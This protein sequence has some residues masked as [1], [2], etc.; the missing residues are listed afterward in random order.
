MSS[1]P[2]LIVESERMGNSQEPSRVDA[3]YFDPQ[4]FQELQRALSHDDPKEDARSDITDSTIDVDHNFDFGKKLQRIV[5]KADEANIKM[6]QLG[7]MF[8]DLRVVGVAPAAS[9]IPTVGGVFNPLAILENIQNLRHPRLKTILSGFEGVVRP[10]EMLLVLG[11]PEAGS[12]TFL[13]MLAN[14]RSEY[15]AVEGDVYYDSISPSDIHNHYRGDVQYSP[16]DDIHFPTLTVDQTLKFASTTRTPREHLTKTRRQFSRKETDMLTTVFGLRHAK[17]TPVGNAAIRGVSG[18]EKKRV[19]IAESLATRALISCWDNSTRGLDS[20]TALE[21]VR[22]LR[23]AT[24]TMH[25]TTVAAIYQASESIYKHFDKVCVLYEGQ[26]AYFGSANKARQYFIDMGYEP[27]NRQT[28]SDFLVAVTDPNG[29]ITRKGATNVPR[30]A[31]EF[32]EYFR[33]SSFAAMNRSDMASYEA[34]YVGNEK[35]ALEYKESARA[36]LAK[37][38]SKGS[39]YLLTIPQQVRAVMLR[40]A[41]I[42]RGEMFVTCL[43][44]FIFTFQALIMGSLFYKVQDATS[45]YFS[46]G[47]VLFFS[48]FFS[49]LTAMAEIP[50]LYAQR[51]IVLR[52]QQAAMYHP[53]VETL[54]LTLVDIPITIVTL[55]IFSIV[56]YFLVGFQLSAGQFFI[57]FLFVV[58]TNLTMKA[59]FRGIA[60]AFTSEPVADSVGG[61]S[62]LAVAIYTG[63][64]I[65]KPSMIGALRWISY[66]NPMRYS[67]EAIITNEFRTLQGTCSSLVPR[68]LGY[69]NVSMANQVCTTL[70]SI[71]GQPY[72]EGSSF[73]LLSYGFKFSHTWMNL[74]IVLG[75]FIG[76]LLCLLAFTELN[77]STSHEHSMA[78]FKRNSKPKQ[79]LSPATP[80]VENLKEKEDMSA[81]KSESRLSGKAGTAVQPP[82]TDIFSWHD[83]SYTVHADSESK[84]LLDDISGY[85]AP[86]KLTALMG[87]SG[88]GKTTL[89]NVLAQRVSTGVVRGDFLVNGQTLPIDFQAQT[90]YCQQMDTHVPTATVREALLFSAQLRQPASVPLE[91]KEAY[92]ELC[93][94]MCGLEEYADASVGSLGV[95]HRKRTTIAVELAAKPKLL[96]FL[97]EPTSGLD[98]QSA[99]SIVSFLRSLADS[100]QAILCT[101]HQPSAELFQVFDRILLLRK[102]GQTVYFGDLGYSATTLINY[103]EQNGARKCLPEEN[104]AEYMLDVMGAGANATSEL[105]WYSIW[106][107]SKQFIGVQ[108]EIDSIHA[109]GRNRPALEATFRSEFATSWLY[110]MKELFIRNIRAYWRDPAYIFAKLILNVVGGLFIGFTFFKAKDTQ[111]GTQNKL[112]SIFMAT[113]LSVPLANQ[114]Q[115]VFIRLR[116]V[117]EIRESQSRM[118]SWTAL[119]TSQ[120]LIEIPWNIFGSLLL[121][122]TWYWTVGFESSRAGYTYLMLGIIFPLYYTTIGQAIASMAPTPEIAALLF[123]TLF[124]FVIGFNGVLEPFRQLKWWSWMYRLSPYTYLIEGL[125][126]QAIGHQ[127]VNCSSV[128]F[129]TINP[130]SG[131]TCRQYMDRYISFAGGYLANPNAASSCQ[132]CSIRT[133]D[134]FLATN[135]NIFYSHHWRNFGFMIAY[136]AFN[137][138]CI[139]VFTWFFRIRTE[140]IFTSIKK[141]FSSRK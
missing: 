57:F 129:V 36:E 51:P 115:G 98:S 15:R 38:A 24:D 26:M 81:E 5:K 106:R 55:S 12:T 53:F 112:F 125:L 39:S 88:A 83:V 111:Q 10:G 1:Q 105:D 84:K 54:A 95:E 7:V 28:T 67:F 23:L 4:G 118:Y 138:C 91:E 86:G 70:G 29:R 80:D 78:L 137:I 73:V 41:Q 47:G 121:F 101:I 22:A 52:H 9:H 62:I 33:K 25:L 76:F 87:E 14:H 65:P 60:A 8:R 132:F 71:P 49:A 134:Q 92:V 13:K 69:E 68:G 30:T 66:I 85:V 131:L 82:M 100:G 139:F 27:A 104:P 31:I 90:A 34:L 75:F 140:S 6:R 113:I 122:F 56:L 117:Y 102:G 32:A 135:F 136:V 110:Q 79:P 126:G 130:P 127:E 45:A 99:W 16:E 18:G 72:V 40:R 114:L 3:N 17:N 58:I 43:K 124:S 21:F 74:G 61:I 11:R 48:L 141:R 128:E 59:W 108:A 94:K 123:S 109:D 19:S 133:T 120:L 20:S 46:R 64:T 119:L 116:D 89:L 93:L 63:Y 35:R 103:F 50:A 107:N 44:I 42:I 77:T 2:E 37:F 97:D 96:L